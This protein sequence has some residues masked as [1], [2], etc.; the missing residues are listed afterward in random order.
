MRRAGSAALGLSLIVIC[1]ACASRPSGTTPV[2]DPN[3]ITYEELHANR[4]T[5]VY[6]AVES[7]RSNWLIPRGTDSFRTPS[8]VIVVFDD[9]QLGDVSTLRTINI[10][11]VV[12]IR[13]YNGVEATARWGLDHGGGVIFVSSRNTPLGERSGADTTGTSG[14]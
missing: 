13:Y 9:T 4:F 8:Q 6:Q 3:L 7:L 1:G 2:K 5:D 14:R 11:S 12:Y 10:T